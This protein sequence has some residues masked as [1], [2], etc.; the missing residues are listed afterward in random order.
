MRTL[1]GVA[2][3]GSWACF[4]DVDSMAPS[5]LSVLTQMMQVISTALQAKR[6]TFALSSIKK[7]NRLVQ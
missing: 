4:S 7:V 3:E 6:D 2:R 1:E 5:S